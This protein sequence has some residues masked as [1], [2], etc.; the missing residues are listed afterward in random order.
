MN[1]IFIR[2]E[3]E[4]GSSYMSVIEELVALAKRMRVD[5]RCRLSGVDVRAFAWNKPRD[6]FEAFDAAIKGNKEIAYVRAEP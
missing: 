6:L 2:V 3:P 1:A 5:V 4:P